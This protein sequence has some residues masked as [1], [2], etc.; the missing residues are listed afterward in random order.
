VRHD[1]PNSDNLPSKIDLCYQPIPVPADVENG[2]IPNLISVT[3]DGLHFQEITPAGIFAHP[4]PR[5]KLFPAIGV[6]ARKLGDNFFAVNDQLIPLL[7]S[8][9]ENLKSTHFPR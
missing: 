4:D 8:H 9:N 3:V 2:A 6:A 5:L 1:I 7:G